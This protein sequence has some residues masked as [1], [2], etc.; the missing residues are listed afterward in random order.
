MSKCRFLS[1]VCGLPVFVLSGYLGMYRAK[2]GGAASMNLSVSVFTVVPA[3]S[4]GKKP[5]ELPGMSAAKAADV[6]VVE[7]PAGRGRNNLDA[8]GRYSTGTGGR[9]TWRLKN[10]KKG[11]LRS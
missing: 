6:H 7:R 11:L 5:M 8:L 2:P 1:Y 10:K 3:T 4:T 9:V